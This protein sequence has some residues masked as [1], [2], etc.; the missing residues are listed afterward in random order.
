LP[1]RVRGVPGAGKFN[2]CAHALVE[3]SANRTNSRRWGIFK[4][5]GFNLAEGDRFS[6]S[7]SGAVPSELRYLPY[8]SGGS[9]SEAVLLDPD[10]TCVSPDQDF[11]PFFALFIG[12][13]PFGVRVIMMSRELRRLSDIGDV[14]FV[15][16]GELP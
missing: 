9:S 10:R 14:R 8:L 3:R 6:R 7:D 15:V 12:E 16:A 5:P 1:S 13:N 11:C 2:H 4:P